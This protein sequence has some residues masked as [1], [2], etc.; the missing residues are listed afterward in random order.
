MKTSALVSP[1]QSVS[2][3]RFYCSRREDS[4]EKNKLAMKNH[5]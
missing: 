1:G 2:N 3:A 4:L 5:E